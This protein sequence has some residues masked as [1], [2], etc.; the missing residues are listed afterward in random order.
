MLQVIGFEGY[1]G[2]APMNFGAAAISD[3]ESVWNAVT[4]SKT[5][6][7]KWRE[8]VVDEAVTACTPHGPLPGAVLSLGCFV[9]RSQAH[10]AVAAILVSHFDKEQDRCLA[11]WADPGSE[12]EW[13]YW[14]FPSLETLKAF[15]MR[16]APLVMRYADHGGDPDP[17]FIRG[18]AYVLDH[19][20]NPI[21]RRLKGLADGRRRSR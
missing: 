13:R 10:G 12:G 20:L 16:V 15:T 21:R 2:D 17:E 7:A 3:S 1:S 9:L 18:Q 8:Y 5:N 11:A 14:L 4:H 19:D 6:I